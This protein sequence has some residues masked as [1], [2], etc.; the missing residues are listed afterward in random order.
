MLY[1]NYPRCVF[2]R[3]VTVKHGLL[4]LESLSPWKLILLTSP[5]GHGG[6]M[7][8]P[9]Q[10]ARTCFFV[11]FLFG[12]KEKEAEVEWIGAGCWEEAGSVTI[13]YRIKYSV[14]WTGFLHILPLLTCFSHRPVIQ[15][16][17]VCGSDLITIVTCIDANIYYVKETNKTIITTACGAA[18]IN[19]ALRS[20]FSQLVS[21]DVFLTLGQIWQNFLL[22]VLDSCWRLCDAFRYYC[23]ALP[24][25]QL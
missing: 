9:F 7:L 18:G 15:P 4:K 23:L 21:A 17:A 14:K 6:D 25:M 3:T 8:I 19:S 24:V 12:V 13:L 5:Q 20:L 2:I 16:S 11:W 22:W 10:C 1:Q